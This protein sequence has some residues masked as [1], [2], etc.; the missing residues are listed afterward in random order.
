VTWSCLFGSQ[1][2]SLGVHS[3][4]LVKTRQN[5]IARDFPETLQ[6][7][8]QITTFVEIATAAFFENDNNM[9]PLGLPVLPR[10]YFWFQT[11]K[12]LI[13]SASRMKRPSTLINH[14]GE[15]TQMVFV[16]GR[17]WKQLPPDVPSPYNRIRGDERTGRSQISSTSMGRGQVGSS[18]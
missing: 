16:P 12:S 17:L 18:R 4:A 1:S 2:R 14:A 5:S 8:L 9:A 3:D 6:F 7:A 10:S 13:F 15:Y 11:H